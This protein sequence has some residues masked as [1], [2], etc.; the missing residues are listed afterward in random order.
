MSSALPWS[1]QGDLS[2]RHDDAVYTN[3]DGTDG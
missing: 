1:V 3:D 2:V